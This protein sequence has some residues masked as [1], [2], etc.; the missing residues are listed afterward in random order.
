MFGTVR[1]GRVVPDQPLPEGSRVE[2]VVRDPVPLPGRNGHPPNHHLDMDL[3]PD[4]GSPNGDP[5]GILDGIAR[6]ANSSNGN[7]PE[8][9]N[10]PEPDGWSW[11]QAIAQ[12]PVSDWQRAREAQAAAEA[13]ARAQAEAAAQQAAL[14]AAR[15]RTQRRV[16]A[17]LVVLA[18]LGAAAYWYYSPARL[19][20]HVR[21]LSRTIK[22]GSVE[23]VMGPGN[24]SMESMQALSMELTRSP[25]AGEV[26]VF[27]GK[28]RT[29]L[30]YDR[31]SHSL[32]AIPGAATSVTP[33]GSFVSGPS[34]SKV[35]D[36][37]IQKVAASGGPVS[38]LSRF[39][40]PP[41]R[42]DA[43]NCS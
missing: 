10:Q 16:G 7:Q 39:C 29:R 12:A 4:G 43:S 18:V 41:G 24:G 32:T 30:I 23:L 6:A 8:S 20:G 26:I 19:R 35:T 21:I 36:S 14:D 27:F 9:G 13:R 15:R 1:D 34:F 28:P 25:N 40:G 31:R 11:E 5:Q 42:V 22:Q 17:L 37:I 38:D 33:C 3:P 2:I